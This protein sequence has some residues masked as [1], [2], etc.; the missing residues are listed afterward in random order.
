MRQDKKPYTGLEWLEIATRSIRFVP[1]R[2]AVRAELY[3]H[4][5]DKTFD[6]MRIFPDL[7]EKEALAMAL[8][9]M[10]DPEEI[11]AE[12]GKIHRPWLGYLWKL[13]QMLVVALLVVVLAT[14]VKD[15]TTYN[16][17][18][19]LFDLTE[20]WQTQG[21]NAAIDCALYADGDP[22]HID[23]S[24]W[25]GEERLALYEVE[26]HDRLGNADVSLT[27]AALWKGEEGNQLWV[28]VRVEYDYPWQKSAIFANYLVGE[29]SLG[30]RY[31]YELTT[32]ETGAH[33]EGFASLGGSQSLTGYTWNLCFK[34]MPEEA[35]WVRL[36]YALR[37]TSD[38]EWVIPLKEVEQP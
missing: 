18:R 7:T 4:L 6:L 35:E 30:N 22:A 38:F 27:E 25:K 17:G 36:T 29:D 2:K 8:D 28:Q 33:K 19:E 23:V 1:D 24:W 3:A 14:A 31:G 16:Y 21:G 32:T 5:E 12:L 20:S 10:G 15:F 34:P 11:G 13:S 37:P 9:R 26:E